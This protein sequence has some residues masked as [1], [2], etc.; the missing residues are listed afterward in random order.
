MLGPEVSF[1]I[2]DES[3]SNEKRYSYQNGKMVTLYWQS[4]QELY[5]PRREFQL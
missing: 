2:S 5:F 4:S 1:R 3:Q